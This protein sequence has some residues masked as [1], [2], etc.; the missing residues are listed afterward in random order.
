MNK[1][2]ITLREFT[3]N[4]KELFRLIH[5][6]SLKRPY[7]RSIARKLFNELPINETETNAM[8]LFLRKNRGRIVYT[9][10]VVRRKRKP[11]P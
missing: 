4:H 9:D 10:S 1:D 3:L 8:L 6:H 11:K 2:T 7:H 5:H